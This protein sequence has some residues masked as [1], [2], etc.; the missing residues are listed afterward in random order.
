MWT[1]DLAGHCEFT[2]VVLRVY[3]ACF[4]EAVSVSLFGKEQILGSG[5]YVLTRLDLNLRHSRD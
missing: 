4:T 2:N 3:A 5:V 1:V